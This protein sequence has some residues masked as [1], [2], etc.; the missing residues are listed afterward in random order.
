[1]QWYHGALVMGV[2]FIVLLAL[3]LPVAFTFIF[4]MLAA[5]I[6]FIGS[7]IGPYMTV[8]S[9]FD[10]IA[11][12]TLAPVPLFVFMGEVMLVSGLAMKSLDA[13]SK[14]VG[15]IP[16]RLSLLATGGGA[17]FGL[18]SGSTMAS[19]ALLG[20]TLVPEMTKRGYSKALS[21]GPILASGGLA[22]II[23]PSSL[24][25]IYGTTAEVPIGRLLVAG[26]IPG[27]IM[28]FNYSVQVLL[29]VKLNPSLAP[30]YEVTPIPAKEKLRL[31]VADLMPLSIIVFL[32][33]GVFILGMATPT[34]AAALGAFGT[35]VVTACYG[36]LSRQVM[37]DALK[38]TVTISAMTLLIIG[39][40][41]IFS[42][43]LGYSGVTRTITT[44]AVGLNLPPLGLLFIM[45]LVVLFLGCFMESVPIM[46]V[47]TPIFVPV[48]RHLGFDPVWF[49][50][51]MLISLQ[52]GLTTP[53]FGLLLFVMK[54]VAPLGTTMRDL[55]S[56][57]L[58]FLLCDAI[59]ILL[60]IAF[61]ML[62]L[63]LPRLLLG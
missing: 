8:L 45:I 53:P 57:A 54:G 58:P 10:S 41:Q 50:V 62:A 40:S 26:A 38:G 7:P 60:V 1:M 21:L 32:V 12:F 30:P 34:E 15:R 14:I 44:Y 33:T 23:P 49:G 6:V 56:S 18:L 29:R 22:M 36:R 17:L 16:A 20:S 52:I 63:W 47:T 4:V 39:G 46:M 27:F 9:L 43:L 28:A 35:V 3:G 11:I 61:P 55:Y 42:Q 31:F 13:L 59:T 48:A 19:T 37:V 5:S 51:I 25:I 2:P 24:A